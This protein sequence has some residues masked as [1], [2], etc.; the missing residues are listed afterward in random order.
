MKR[1]K[2]PGKLVTGSFAALI[3]SLITSTSFGQEPGSRQTREFVQASAQSDQFEILEG[4]TALAESSDPNVR[5]FTQDMIETHQQTTD[6]LLRAAARAGLSPPNPGISGDQS[7][8]LA[9]LQSARGANFD[10]T[11]IRQQALAHQSALVTRQIYAASGDDTTIKQTAV[12]AMPIISSHLQ[13]AARIE[14][15]IGL[16]PR[17]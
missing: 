17:E 11:F 2:Q 16:R 12:A 6:T 4:Y 9:A 7:M 5:A 15:K 8:M 1:I 14:A 10:K 3:C 13:M